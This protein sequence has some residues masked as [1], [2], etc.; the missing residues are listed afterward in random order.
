M[1][2]TQISTAGVKDDAVTSGK[3][4]ANAVGS[5]EL[6]DNA[7]D[8]AA[9]ADDA[10][11]NA[12]V[13]NNAI[14]TNE[15]VNNAVTTV[16]VAD[17]AITTA[18][19]ADSQIN[20]AKIGANAA[21]AG[22]KISPSFTSNITIT[23]T[24]P[25]IFLTDSNNTSD[26]SIQNEN[27]NLNLYDETNSASRVRIVADGK[28]GIGTTSPAELLHLQSTAGNTKLRL[29]Q[30]GSTTDAVNG[31]IHFGNSTDGQLCEIR[32]YTSGS[33]NSGYLQFRTTNSGSDVTAM[34]INT[35]G[36]VG[37]GTASPSG[38]KLHISHGNEL[39]IY[40]LGGYNYQAK[41]ESTDAEAAIV[42]EDNGSTNDGNRIG[43]ISDV[44]AFTTA[45]TERMRIDSDGNVGIGTTSPNSF[46]NYKTLTIQGGTSGAGIDLEKSDGNIYGRLFADAD[47]LQI[48]SHQS[49]DSIRFETDGG[50]VRARITSDGLCFG[51]DTA[52]ANA[53]DD[54]EEGT[55][56]PTVNS[57]MSLQ[58]SYDI[59]SYVKI[60]KTV[61]IRGLFY[62]NSNPSSN[63][64]MTISLPFASANYS[65]IA[66][67]GATGVMH[68]QI[69]GASNGVVL[70]I[71]DNV[72]Y[73]EFYK[74]GGSGNWA[75]VRN[76]DWQSGQEIYV[77]TTYFAA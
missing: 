14:N 69:A 42:I 46:S 52:A 47:G 11:T 28:V 73:A 32:G 18:K 33:N 6:A 56:V 59:F 53:L 64:V 44:M 31:A 4:P 76:N 50:T 58:S 20:N 5:S 23:N 8:T 2:L 72:T 37:I 19:I 43:V 65:Q 35:A 51:S 49:G 36:N 10:V 68:R 67:A 22:S 45:G 41:F 70:Y 9:I 15:I 48:Q 13:A 34:T 61:T 75:P 77:Q 21:I 24:Q 12:K 16:K 57:N 26:F 27:G 39:G 25:K 29:T 1:T 38:G 71:Q 30:S 55:Y 40:T 62:P 60:G 54:Y 66:G 17:N 7:V 74:N 63:N 3:I